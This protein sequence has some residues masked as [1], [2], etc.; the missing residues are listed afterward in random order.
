MPRLA[1]QAF[2]LAEAHRPLADVEDPPADTATC[3][4][5]WARLDRAVCSAN[6]HRNRTR[7]PTTSH[8]RAWQ[9][10]AAHRARAEARRA[11]ASSF[12][13]LDTAFNPHGQEAR[14]KAR[15]FM[16]SAARASSRLQAAVEELES[17]AASAQA[18]HAADESGW[19]SDQR[20]LTN[21]LE[22]M[23]EATARTLRHELQRAEIALSSQQV[24]P[25][26]QPWSLP[27]RP[28]GAETLRPSGPSSLQALQACCSHQPC[29]HQPWSH[30]PCSHQPCSHQPWARRVVRRRS[31]G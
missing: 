4:S 24:A 2:H 6:S 21:R 5:L 15:A 31:L 14:L 29:S 16:A 25:S 7:W 30:Q 28:F 22:A 27:P 11:S 1:P 26:H 10:A 13:G 9:V 3:P 20:L 19:L 12:T 18:A 8:A 17:Q 23:A